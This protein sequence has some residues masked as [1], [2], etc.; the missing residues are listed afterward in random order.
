[1]TANQI[2]YLNYLENR[3]SNQEQE[4]ITSW[5]DRSNVSNQQFAN[6]TQRLLYEETQRHNQNVEI[7]ALAQLGLNERGVRANEI[8]AE[9]NMSNARTN[10]MN[11]YTN[12]RN[13]AVNER[14][15]QTNAYNAASNR[16]SANAAVMS[17]SAAQQNA[18]T[19]VLRL[20][21]DYR[22][23]LR[24]EGIQGTQ[25]LASYSQAQ[26]AAG[27]LAEE[28]RHDKSEE[29]IGRFNAMSNQLKAQGTLLRGIAAQTT[30]SV[31]EDKSLSERAKNWLS[32]G[33]DVTRV[34]SWAKLQ[35]GA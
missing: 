24:T 31:Q 32:V 21:E 13:A 33:G 23:N 34:A 16:I 15:A 20:Q 10:L 12:Q 5:R 30:A 4:R 19:N 2:A 35:L 9:A 25:A 6:Q 22:H 17:A 26:T 29:A 1:M 28:V 14:N 11:A 27:R 7:Q 8:S 3:R 18:A